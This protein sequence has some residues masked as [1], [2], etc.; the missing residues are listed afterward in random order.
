MSVHAVN[1]SWPSKYIHKKLEECIQKFVQILAE[2]YV[3]KKQHERWDRNLPRFYLT[4]YLMYTVEYVF[5]SISSYRRSSC[6]R[7][8]KRVCAG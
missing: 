8:H 4:D 6:K 2:F 7:K 3:P 5:C 1:K